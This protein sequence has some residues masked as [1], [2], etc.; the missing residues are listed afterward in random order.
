VD[1]GLAELMPDRDR[2]R[3]WTLLV[4]GAPK[5]HVDLDD[6]AYLMELLRAATSGVSLTKMGEDRESVKNTPIVSPIVISG[7]ALGLGTQKALID[8]AITLKASNPTSRRSFKDPEKPQWDDILELRAAY[9]E[10]LHVLA[11]W[12]VQDALSVVDKTLEAV[13]AGRAGGSG[14]ASDKVAVLR[15]G[16]RLM[17]HMLR[18]EGAWTIRGPNARRLEKWLANNLVDSEGA[19]ITSNE[20]TLTLEVLPWALRKWKFPTKPLAGE[21]GDMDTPVYIKN[22][23]PEDSLFGSGMVLG[24]S[25][26]LL[27]EAWEDHKRGRQEKR[28][29]TAESFREQ[30]KALGWHSTQQKIVNGGGRRASYFRSSDDVARSTIRRAIGG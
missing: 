10:G 4:D 17:D 3:A 15:A 26:D 5:S 25:A 6:P 2:P 22:Y 9:P 29:T 23:E 13:R 18:L 20:N 24:F 12:Y 27:A 14:R 8:R 21:R 11:G 1:G 19:P 7:E 16:A 28:T 30:A